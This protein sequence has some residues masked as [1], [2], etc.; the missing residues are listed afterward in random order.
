M[1]S[2][3]S[4]FLRLASYINQSRYMTG[5]KELT[6]GYKTS[7][8]MLGIRFSRLGEWGRSK[9]CEGGVHVLT[10]KNTNNYMTYWILSAYKGLDWYTYWAMAG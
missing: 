3:F 6:N 2:L 1:L 10:K 7:S 9:G 4:I 8:W 5:T